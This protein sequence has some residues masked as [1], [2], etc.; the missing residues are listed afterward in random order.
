MVESSD[1]KE[2]VFGPTEAEKKIILSHLG[3]EASVDPGFK[4][5]YLLSKV[6]SEIR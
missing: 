5:S 4:G 2:G 1:A 6:E 3:E